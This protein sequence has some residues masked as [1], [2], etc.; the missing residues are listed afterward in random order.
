M[1]KSLRIFYAICIICLIIVTAV[2]LCNMGKLGKESSLDLENFSIDSLTDEQIA[3]ET[4]ARAYK[5]STNYKNNSGSGASN[6]AQLD[7]DR[8]KFSCESI[9][10]I[11]RVSLTKAKDCTLTLNIS[12]E[13]K[14]GK[15]KIVIVRDDMI[16]DYVEFNETKELTYTVT[17]EHLFTVKIMCEDAELSIEVTREF[18]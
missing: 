4:K 15:A 10:G 1:R 6:I 11:D 5:S 14:S 2:Y 3:T 13:L 17:G 12:S 9:T 7:S 16:L 8:I 18:E